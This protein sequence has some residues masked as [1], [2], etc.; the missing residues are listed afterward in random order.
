GGER[1]SPLASMRLV[2][3]DSPLRRLTAGG[4]A[5]M[6]GHACFQTLLVAYLVDRLGM[7]LALAGGMYAILQV[8]GACSRVVIGWSVDRLGNARVTLTCVAVLSLV[9]SLLV[10]GFS[11]AWPLLAIGIACAVAGT[12]SSGWYGAF[13]SEV[14]RVA[15]A[16]RAGFATGGVLFFVYGAHVAAPV[17]AALAVALT[18]SY[19]PVFVAIGA[20]AGVAALGFVRLDAP[21]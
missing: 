20:L 16:E 9:G 14:A 1:L 5:L 13:L 4:A 6:A 10:A 21:G 7:G 12:G 2:L 17:V 18:G 8:F 15:T 11:S 3:G 19:V